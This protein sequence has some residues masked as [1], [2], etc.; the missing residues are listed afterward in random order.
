KKIN[1]LIDLVIELLKRKYGILSKLIIKKVIHNLIYITIVFLLSISLFPLVIAEVSP[2]GSVV[3]AILIAVI[4]LCGYFLWKTVNKFHDMLDVMIRGTL[5]A[6]DITE[7]EDIDI[8][9]RLERDKMVSEVK[10]SDTSPCIG[11]TIGDTRLRTRTGATILFIL[12][13]EN[14]IDPEPAVRIESGDVLI[15]LGT[16]E[17]RYNAQTYLNQ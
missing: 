2:Y 17:A 11:T 1:E 14:L 5:L 15:V 8:I 9:E 6:Y 10:I 7:H 4:G 16:D 12:R 3:G 13:R